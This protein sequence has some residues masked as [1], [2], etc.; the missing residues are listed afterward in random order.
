[1][2]TSTRVALSPSIPKS[3][4]MAGSRCGASTSAGSAFG[5]RAGFRCTWASHDHRAVAVRSD[6]CREFCDRGVRGRAVAPDIERGR[7]RAWCHG[8][9]GTPGLPIRA[10]L[11]AAP[12]P[13]QC[14][15][16]STRMGVLMR[17]AGRHPVSAAAQPL[18]SHPRH[19][20]AQPDRPGSHARSLATHWMVRRGAP[21][22]C[23]RCQR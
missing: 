18:H 22:R 21:G 9:E 13:G 19:A 1:M 10:R 8:A 15:A 23:A 7:Y 12:H 5:A 11:V 14:L 17:G 6:L 2:V 20:V 3:A 4:A 16:V